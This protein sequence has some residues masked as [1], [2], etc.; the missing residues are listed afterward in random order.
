MDSLYISSPSLPSPHPT[1]DRGLL[2]ELALLDSSLGALGSASASVRAMMV[3][4]HVGGCWWW[5]R[6]PG[7]KTLVSLG[8]SASVPCPTFNDVN[9]TMTSTAVIQGA[10]ETLVSG[11]GFVFSDIGTVRL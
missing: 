9:K 4:H 2:G 5:T 10:H 6:I 11:L 7:R 1:G 8:N 3:V